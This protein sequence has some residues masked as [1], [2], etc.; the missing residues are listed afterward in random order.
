MKKSKP[1]PIKSMRRSQLLL[2]AENVAVSFDAFQDFYRCFRK[3]A[4]LPAT[5]GDVYEVTTA[6]ADKVGRICRL[7]KHAQRYDPLPKTRERM[8]DNIAGIVVYMEMLVRT[9]ALDMLCGFKR[10]LRKAVD[11]HGKK[12]A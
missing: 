8:A 3:A 11:Q 7:V 2:D 10:E 5:R 12:P 9:Y 4:N 1:N 6:L